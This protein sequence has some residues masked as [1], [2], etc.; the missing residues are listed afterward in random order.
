MKDQYKHYQ[1]FN[2]VTLVLKMH[3]FK[4]TSTRLFLKS[5]AYCCLYVS[6]WGSCLRD[7]LDSTD[8]AVTGNMAGD[9]ASAGFATAI[10]LS[11]LAAITFGENLLASS[12]MSVCSSVVVRC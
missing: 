7:S 4:F 1:S 2:S 11:P 3:L 12:A 10:M 6:H 8:N 5:I 9:I